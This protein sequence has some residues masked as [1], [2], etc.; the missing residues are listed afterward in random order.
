MHRILSVGL[1]LSLSM[2]AV[3]CGDD[4]NPTNPSNN[5]TVR[6]TAPLLPGNEVP[7]IVAP[8]AEAGGTGSV[9]V[10]WHLTRDASQNV[11]AATADFTVALAG[12]P[13]STSVIAAHIH[14]GVA[15]QNGG[16]LVSLV[17]AAGDFVLNAS[18]TGTFSKTISG[19]PADQAQAIVNNPAAYYFNVH[20]P[21]NG[22]GFARGQLTVQ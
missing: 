13:A 4:D 7:P 21:L 14:P 3:A 12:F 15:G 5:N 18:G 16:P 2:F 1:A 20:S 6:M 8:N 17:L 9:I 22:G 11:T 10:T 19:V